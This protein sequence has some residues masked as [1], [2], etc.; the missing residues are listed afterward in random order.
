MAVVQNHSKVNK[1]HPLPAITEEGKIANLFPAE[2]KNMQQDCATL[3]KYRELANSDIEV[4]GSIHF[5]YKIE[6]LLHS[7]KG[8][9]IVLR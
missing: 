3:D 9:K 7:E 2:L 5:R 8:R 6:T 4:K 1:L